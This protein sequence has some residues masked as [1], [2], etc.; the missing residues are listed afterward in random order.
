MNGVG[1]PVIYLNLYCSVFPSGI[2]RASL[3]IYVDNH[4]LQKLWGQ[5]QQPPK[6]E[7]T[8]VYEAENGWL[9]VWN[10]VHFP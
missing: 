2:S 8:G 1:F 3:V 6:N 10:I 9:V 7:F 4:P 5:G